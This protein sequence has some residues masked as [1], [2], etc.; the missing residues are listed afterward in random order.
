PA[1]VVNRGSYGFRG[2]VSALQIQGFDRDRVLILEDGERVVG[3]VGGA[4]DLST[5][6]TGDI[7]R[8]EIVSGPTSALYGSAALGGVVNIITAPPRDFGPSGRARLEYRS[9]P[10]VVGQG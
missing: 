5:I 1:V 9:L 3:D 7:D 4:I 8:I 6:P 10:G 2:V